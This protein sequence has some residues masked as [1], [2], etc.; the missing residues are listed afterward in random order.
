MGL[1]EANKAKLK[2]TQA[3][4]PGTQASGHTP[5]QKETQ[6]LGQEVK[7]KLEAAG[8]GGCCE[9]TQGQQPDV[10]KLGLSLQLGWP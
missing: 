4:D 2:T 6:S 3:R 5:G 8:R 10:A 7:S 9:M 1:G